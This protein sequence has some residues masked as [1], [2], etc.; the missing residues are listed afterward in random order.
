[1]EIS[2][3]EGALS[4]NVIYANYF[5]GKNSRAEFLTRKKGDEFISL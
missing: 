5:K 3:M 4:Y 2:A 1:M